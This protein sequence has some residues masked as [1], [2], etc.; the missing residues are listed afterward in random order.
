LHF[1]RKIKAPKSVKK[2]VER[3][4]YCK[5]VEPFTFILK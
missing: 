3:F 1:K 5:P 2:F 4:D